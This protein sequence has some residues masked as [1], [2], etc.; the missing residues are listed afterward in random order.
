MAHLHLSTVVLL[1]DQPVANGFTQRYDE[2]E[3]AMATVAEVHRLTCGPLG[4]GADLT[5]P[6]AVFDSVSAVH[7]APRVERLRRRPRR[8]MASCSSPIDTPSSLE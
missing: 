5:L 8:A 1:D 7:S 4:S 6:A 3:R 2:V